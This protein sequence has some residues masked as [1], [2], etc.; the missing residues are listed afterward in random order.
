MSSER[1]ESLRRSVI[2]AIQQAV[3][4]NVEEGLKLYRQLLTP[5]MERF[6]TL[7]RDQRPR[8]EQFPLHPDPSGQQMLWIL[9]DY[10]DFLEQALSTKAKGRS[11]PS[12]PSYSAPGPYAF[13]AATWGR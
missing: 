5:M 10:K 11:A 8:Y 4:S 9:S 2:R 7:Y 12:S 6:E 13:A 1:S 3:P